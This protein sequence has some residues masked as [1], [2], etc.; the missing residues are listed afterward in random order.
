MSLEA[1]Q[2][3]AGHASIETTRV[4]LH[5]ADDLLAEQYRRASSPSCSANGT[6]PPNTARPDEPTA[7][8]DSSPTSSPTND[9]QL[10][11]TDRITYIPMPGTRSAGDRRGTGHLGGLGYR[12]WDN[13]PHLSIGGPLAAIALPGSGG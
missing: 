9:H 13:G 12:T 5:L 7:T 6:T 8:T 3:Q 1:L 10:E 11:Q 2:A 4:Y